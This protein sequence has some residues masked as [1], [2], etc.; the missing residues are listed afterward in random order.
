M[1]ATATAPTTTRVALDAPRRPASLSAW[2]TLARRRFALSARTPR[3]LF[4]P[5]L[6]PIPENTMLIGMSSPAVAMATY[7]M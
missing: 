1:A 3:E 4:V 5:L 7:V 2:A 6:T